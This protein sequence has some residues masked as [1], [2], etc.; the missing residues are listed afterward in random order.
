MDFT[1][2]SCERILECLIGFFYRFYPFH[3]NNEKCPCKCK[4][5]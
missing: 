2:G 4:Y 5:C 1:N 3:T